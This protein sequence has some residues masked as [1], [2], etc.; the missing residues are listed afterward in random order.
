MTEF[1]MRKT[2]TCYSIVHAVAIPSGHELMSTVDAKF[3]AW[4]ADVV[5]TTSS[6]NPAS[7]HSAHVEC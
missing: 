5:L 2:K 1:I 6:L 3:F 4:P 7:C